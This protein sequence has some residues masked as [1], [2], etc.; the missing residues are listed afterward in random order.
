[1][2]LLLDILLGLIGLAIL[3]GMFYGFYWL[4]K[5]MLTGLKKHDD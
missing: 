5:Y 4:L 1:M 3:G 2:V